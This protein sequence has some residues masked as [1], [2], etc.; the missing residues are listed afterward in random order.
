MITQ[1]VKAQAATWLI[2]LAAGMLSAEMEELGLG[3]MR[4]NMG[5]GSNA[6]KSWMRAEWAGMNLK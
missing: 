4:K 3:D 2:T 6:K 5:L 1:Y